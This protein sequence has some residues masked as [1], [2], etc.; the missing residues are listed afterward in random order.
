AD[1]EAPGEE[2]EEDLEI[3]EEVEAAEAP[4]KADAEAPGEEAEEDLEIEEVEEEDPEALELQEVD[5]EEEEGTS[6]PPVPDED[7]QAEPREAAAPEPPATEPA[8]DAPRPRKRK[9]PWFE[10]FFNDD[11]LRTVPPPTQKQIA[12]QV[13]FIEQVLGLERGATILDVGC[14][15]GMHAIE[16]TKRGYLVVGLDLSLPMLS[17]AGDEAQDMGLKINFLHG[18][19]RDMVF[20]GSFDAVLCWS[21]TF[22]YFDDEANR[23]VMGRLYKAL[24]PR[25]LLLL[26]VVNRDFVV[27]MQPNLIWFEGDGCVC[28]E[29]TSFNY[30]T[31]RLEVKRTVILDDGRQREAQYSIRLYSIHELGQLMHQ[32]GFRVAEISGGEATRGVFLG[33]SSPRLIILAERRLRPSSPPSGIMAAPQSEASMPPPPPEPREASGE[34]SEPEERKPDEP[35]PDAENG[36]P[37]QQG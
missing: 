3:E 8:P 27:P 37:D 32:Q 11:Y 18:D 24:K 17:R 13:D 21:T 10:T 12:R 20:E 15:L 4:A 33:S 5:P 6:P 29:E 22:G 1:A 26:D 23:K 14:G 36:E 19:M 30:I 34:E 31:S 25:G 16:L 9:R 35:E 2:A 28:M 7:P